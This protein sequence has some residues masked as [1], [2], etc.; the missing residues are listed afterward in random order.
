MLRHSLEKR[1]DTGCKCRL[2]VAGIG[3]GY[4]GLCEFSLRVEKLC[5]TTE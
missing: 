4:E 2:G 3:P 1:A 5:A